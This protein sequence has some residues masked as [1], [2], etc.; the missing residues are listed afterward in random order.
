MTPFSIA[1]IQLHVSVGY[2]H[3]QSGELEVHWP[4]VRKRQSFGDFREERVEPFSL[5]GVSE[6]S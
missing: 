3:P 5:Q 4:G 2:C 1:G 6:G